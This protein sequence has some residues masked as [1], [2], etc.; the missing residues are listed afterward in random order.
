VEGGKSYPDLLGCGAYPLLIVSERVISVLKQNG[1]HCFQEFPV[2]VAKVEDGRA[3]LED[4]P[5]YYRLEITG[6]CMIDFAASGITVQGICGRC[7]ELTRTPA[8]TPR[9]EL[10]NGS[11]DGSDLFRDQRYFPRRLFTTQRI[12]DLVKEHGLTNWE[13]EPMGS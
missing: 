11:W 6:E 7:G 3:R 10:I 5:N 1:V 13:F 4:A 12:V 9:F 2:R 8:V